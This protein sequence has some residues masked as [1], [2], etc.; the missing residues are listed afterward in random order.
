MSK[1][2]ALLRQQ[3]EK[4]TL[5]LLRAGKIS[6]R[7]EIAAALGLSKNT[8]S[9]IVDKFIKEGVVKEVGSDEQG[10]VGRPRI[11]LSLQTEAY[12]SI[13][14]LIQHSYIQYVVTDYCSAVLDQGSIVTDANDPDRCIG[15][16][17]RLCGELIGR[18]P[19][20]L[21][22][23]VAVPALVDPIEGVVHF[24]SHLSW[25]NVRLKDRMDA[26]LPVATKVLNLVKA[27][28]LAPSSGMPA[29]HA[30]NS[31]YLRIDEGVGGAHIIDSS[32]YNGAS[33]TAGEVGHLCVE[34]NGPLCTCGQRGCLEAMVSLPALAKQLR[35]LYPEVRAE[36]DFD[37]YWTED[38]AGL[39]SADELMR[40]TG[41]YVGIALAP[42]IALLNPGYIVVDSPLDKLDA[43]KQS[44]LSTVESRALK[45]PT[46]QTKILFIKSRC[47]S[48]IG[49]AFAVILDFEKE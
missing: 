12:K 45:Y 29:E 24:S 10:S 33:W 18:H 3:N 20:V 27:A 37:A 14:I 34:P 6:S 43:F 19:E 16:L 38:A 22:I 4:R 41:R 21:G 47:A 9:L 17:I 30:A 8:I 28:A 23:G 15:T 11:Q 7:Q 44:V 39:S 1:G 46:E 42:V 49:A 32:I 5:A 13:G 35:E 40:Q 26:R 25:R 31:F 2:T 48:S 36:G